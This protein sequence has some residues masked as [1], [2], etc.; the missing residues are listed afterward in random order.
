MNPLTLIVVND[1]R[2]NQCGR[3]YNERLMIARLRYL[4]FA[5]WAECVK[6]AENWNCVHGGEPTDVPTM[7]KAVIEIDAYYQRHLRE[8]DAGGADKPD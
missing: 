4:R 3:S 2:G 8:L 6:R 5:E 7:A 1:G